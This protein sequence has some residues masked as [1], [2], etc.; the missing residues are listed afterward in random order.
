MRLRKT[1]AMGA[2]VAIILALSSPFPR[3]AQ[4][5]DISTRPYTGLSLPAPGGAQPQSE[6]ADRAKQH[7][8]DVLRGMGGKPAERAKTLEGV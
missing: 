8:L 3:Q 5:Q 4:G 2:G 7:A 6:A 1:A